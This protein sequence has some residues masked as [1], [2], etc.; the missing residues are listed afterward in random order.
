MNLYPVILAG[1]CGRRLWP[2]SPEAHPK[3]FLPLLEGSSPLQATLRRLQAIGGAQPATVVASV[4]HRFLVASQVKAMGH[5][6]RRLYL[7]PCGRGT[8]PAVAL[9]A[10]ELAAEDPDAVMLVLPADPDIPDTAGFAEAVRTAGAAAAAGRLAIFGVE[11]RG[12]ET[13]FGYI[14]R[15]EALAAAPGCHDVA[16]FV[17]KPELEIAARF[18]ETGRH[19]WN[20]GMFLF[21]AR[22]LLAELQRLDPE[23]AAACGA[24]AMSCDVEAGGVRVIARAAFERCAPGSIDHAVL[25]RTRL[26]AMVPVRF[27]WSD[28]G[29]WDALPETGEPR[30]ARI[31]HR[32]WGH[33][34]DIDAGCRYRVK[35]ITVEPGQKLSLQWHHHRAEHWVVVSGTARVTRGDQ[36]L[37]LAENQSAYIELGQVHRLENPGKVPLKIIEVQT[38]AYLGEDD[39]VRIEDVYQRT[40][41]GA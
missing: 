25:E 19:Y 37:L 40:T 18:L 22:A 29:T 12:P 27:G 41:Q 8:A 32:P 4:E 30:A 7:E 3:Q 34:E 33:Y 2:L 24:A 21:G 39:I 38:G 31:V 13:G 28:I 6:L 15:G 16:A 5:V 10:Q 1:G 9:V 35:R 20:S 17:E 14:E 36:V 23:L 26:A 11:P